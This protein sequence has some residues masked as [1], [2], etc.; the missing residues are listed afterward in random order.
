MNVKL[1]S[2]L[3]IRRTSMRQLAKYEY[4]LCI[5]KH[6]NAK[7]PIFNNQTAITLKA[8]FTIRDAH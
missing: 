2:I 4:G 5:R 3:D 6:S 8:S 1:D 7:C